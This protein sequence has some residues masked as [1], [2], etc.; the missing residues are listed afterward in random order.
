MFM[1][2]LIFIVVVITLLLR[3]AD[4]ETKAL[5]NT[6]QKAIQEIVMAEKDLEK[7][8]AE[9]GFVEAFGFY[10]D[11]NAVIKRENDTLVYGRE[12]IRNYYSAP[13]FAQ[14]SVTWSPD[15]TD[16]TEQGNFGYTYGKFNWRSKDGAGKTTGFTGIFHTVWKKQTDGS[17]KFVWD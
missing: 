8:V 7:M 17:W 16:A 5:I 14:A 6:R 11:S 13:S 15:F 1:R 10:A 3:C 12:A 2:S 9:K 4:T